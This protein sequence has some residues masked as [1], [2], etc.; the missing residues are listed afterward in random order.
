MTR[1]AKHRGDAAGVGG[2]MVEVVDSE[3]RVGDG[4]VQPRRLRPGDIAERGRGC[5]ELGGPYERP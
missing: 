4:V 5:A 3:L 2:E 1:R